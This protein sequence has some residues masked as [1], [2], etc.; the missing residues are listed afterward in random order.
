M[1]RGGRSLRHSPFLLPSLRGVGVPVR[2]E[3]AEATVP[4]GCG[5]LL[6]GAVHYTLPPASELVGEFHH[7]AEQGGTVVAGEFDEAG[8]VDEAA[9]F[10]ELAGSC[11]AFLDPIAGFVPGLS[12][13]ETC[14]HDGQAAKLR[15]CYL[16]V[17]EQRRRIRLS[18]PAC[19]LVERRP[20]RVRSTS[21]R[22][23]GTSWIARRRPATHR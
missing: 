8:L 20:V 19:P 17:V 2:F 12:A 18:S 6:G 13:F 22:L 7:G 1:L 15:R 5:E 3:G 14:L 16:Q 21:R 23:R 9:E 11:A 10:D 4:P